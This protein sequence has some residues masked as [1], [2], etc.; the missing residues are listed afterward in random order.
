MVNYEDPGE[1]DPF[2]LRQAA[3]ERMEAAAA[4]TGAQLA[5]TASVT[6]A[7]GAAWTGEAQVAFQS[8]VEAVTPELSLLMGSLA[9]TAEALFAYANEIAEIHAEQEI[10]ARRRSRIIGESFDLHTE[11][12]AAREDDGAQAV[13]RRERAEE[14][15]RLN[16]NEM[17]EVV[18]EWERLVKRRERADADFVGALSSRDVRGPLFNVGQDA[19][20]MTPEELLALL[21]AMSPTDM[22]VL[23]AAHPDV[24]DRLLRESTPE[25]V[26]EWWAELGESNPTQQDELVQAMPALFG[27]LGG[28]PALTRAAA[29]RILAS[30]RLK[31]LRQALR[32][33]EKKG[34]G[35]YDPNEMYAA[36]AAGAEYLEK[37]R[38][39]EGEIGYLERVQSGDV[40]L[41][42]YDR[43][44]NYL[45]EMFGNP[46]DADVLMSFMPGTNT[47]MESFYDRDGLT[48]MTRYEVENPPEG[49]DVAGFVVMPGDFPNL[50]NLI[51]EGPE[52]NWFA[53]VLG[54]RYAAFSKE[55]DVI[56][57]GLPVVSVEHSFGSAVAGVAEQAGAEFDA[58][59]MLAGIGMLNGWETRDGCDYYAAQGPNDI[60]RNFDGAEMWTLGYGVKPDASNGII[61]RPTGFEEFSSWAYTPFSVP[62]LVTGLEQHNAIISADDDVNGPVLRDVNRVLRDAALEGSPQ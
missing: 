24:R 18:D 4:L 22:R 58:R 1:G 37:L 33:V 26:A 39:L 12:Q 23:V 7:S 59:Y 57:G 42:L 47:S 61:E 16:D 40:Q 60:N 3:R 28:I 32:D 50:D 55:L 41:Y 56:T 5:V 8:E 9:G 62:S 34:A 53:Q 51:T 13:D 27:A 36:E 43:E 52:N 48:A 21:G 6:A 25:Q 29:N 35:D 17:L 44:R 20:C 15:I 19:S 10:L 31:E 30:E 49:V 2:V 11:L 46:D 14:D 54:R 38:E 45:I